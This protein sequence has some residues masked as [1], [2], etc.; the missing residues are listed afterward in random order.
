V[1]ELRDYPPA[2]THHGSSAREGKAMGSLDGAVQNLKTEIA[3]CVYVA[4]LLCQVAGNV[5]IQWEIK[6]ILFELLISL[7][8]CSVLHSQRGGLSSKKG[9]TLLV[10]L[11]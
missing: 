10:G 8:Q 2:A 7:S 11:T 9:Q 3:G 6:L 4:R 5:I 1:P